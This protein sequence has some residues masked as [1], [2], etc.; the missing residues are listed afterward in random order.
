M[1]VLSST[2]ISGLHSVEFR[3]DWSFDLKFTR[4]GWLR[5]EGRVVRRNQG[6]RLYNSGRTGVPLGL[7]GA[8]YAWQG[9][10]RTGRTQRAVQ[11]QIEADKA[12][13][14]EAYDALRKSTIRVYTTN[15]VKSDS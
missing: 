11:T 14:V 9:P 4:L 5:W 15:P 12:L 7:D 8:I 3:T 6:I 13:I 2:A 10:V 1:S